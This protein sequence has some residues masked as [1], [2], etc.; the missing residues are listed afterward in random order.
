MMR[1][2]NEQLDGRLGMMN[3]G[4]ILTMNVYMMTS[5]DGRLGMMWLTILI[6]IVLMMMFHIVMIFTHHWYN[7]DAIAYGDDI[8]HGSLS[9]N[10]L[11]SDSLEGVTQEGDT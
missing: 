6:V 3:Y 5:L 11:H 1:F 4:T 10:N 7:T 9:T 2:E 8:W